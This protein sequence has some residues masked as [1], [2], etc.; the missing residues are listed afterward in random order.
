MLAGTRI[1]GLGTTSFTMEFGVARG[2]DPERLV[3]RGRGVIVL[4]DYASGDKVA[5]PPALRARL[6]EMT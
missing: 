6:E 4:I 3:A 1:A 2:D 5:M